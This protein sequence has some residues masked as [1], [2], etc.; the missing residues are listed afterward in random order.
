MTVS[1]E[2]LEQNPQ[3]AFVLMRLG[4]Y[5]ARTRTDME[6]VVEWAKEYMKDREQHGSQF[7]SFH[8]K[9]T[10]LVGEDSTFTYYLFFDQGK[11]W[12]WKSHE[13]KEEMDQLFLVDWQNPP[14]LGNN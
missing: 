1:Q 2:Q 12:C 3:F 7:P 9:E 11:L 13:E 14:F 4:Q 8:G 10:F 6:K 5:F